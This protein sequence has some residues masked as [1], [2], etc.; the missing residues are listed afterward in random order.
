MG[1]KALNSVTQGTGSIILKFSQINT[2]NWVI[3]NG[4]F[5]KILLCNLT[6]DEANWEFPEEAT[7]FPNVLK[8]FMEESANK[9]CKSL[10]IP[11]EATVGNCWIH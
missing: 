2:F 10:P 11:A 7:E 4:Y 6:H 5:N 1:E 3:E 9:F 8:N